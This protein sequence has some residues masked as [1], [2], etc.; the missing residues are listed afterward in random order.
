MKNGNNNNNN[1]NVFIM[2]LWMLNLSQTVESRKI[3]FISLK[4]HTIEYW[5]NIFYLL[6]FISFF[7]FDIFML[8]RTRTI[9]LTYFMQA[10]NKEKK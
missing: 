9:D 4:K 6:F 8:W 1:N 3:L 10:K 5:I 7:L 2:N